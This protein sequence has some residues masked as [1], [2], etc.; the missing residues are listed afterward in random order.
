M[1]L[2]AFLFT[3]PVTGYAQLPMELP[4]PNAMVTLT[5]PFTPPLIKGII[6]YPENPLQFDF[7]IDPGD[8]DF[9][10]Q[11]APEKTEEYQK[12]VKYFLAAL[13]VPEND[14]WVNL[15]PYEKNRIIPDN[16]GKT[17][18]GRD[19]LSQDYILKQITASLMYP[20]KELG[21]EF[22]QKVYK[23]AQARFGTTD[24]PV[25]TFNK[26]WIIPDK[27]SVY[28][29]NNI[30]LL[31]DS[32]LKVMLEEDYLAL[33]Q[34]SLNKELGTNQ[35]VKKD[36]K[37]IS[38]VSS[39]IVREIILPAIEK[40]VNEGKNFA[41]LRQINNSLILATWYKT[42]LKESLLGK[43]YADRS[44][45]EGINQEDIKDNE[46]IYGQYLEA[47]KKGV[48]NYIKEEYDP[49]SQD[50][51]ARK[52]VSGGYSTIDA[53]LDN[54]ATSKDEAMLANRIERLPLS[55]RV[56]ASFP[57]AAD[58][59]TVNLREPNEARSFAKTPD[60]AMLAKQQVPPSD[61]SETAREFEKMAA[62]LLAPYFRS[63]GEKDTIVD[64]LKSKGFSPSKSGGLAKRILSKPSRSRETYRGSRRLS[65]EVQK[66]IFLIN[67]QHRNLPDFLRALFN[68]LNALKKEGIAVDPRLLG[69]RSHTQ[70]DV[71][72]E[73]WFVYPV[74][75]QVEAQEQ[76]IYEYETSEGEN[77]VGLI[78][79]TNGEV[80]PDAQERLIRYIQSNSF[81]V[82][83]RANLGGD[84]NWDKDGDA[85][86]IDTSPRK[87][88]EKKWL[89]KEYAGGDYNLY[90]KDLSEHDM[91]KILIEYYRATRQELQ[92]KAAGKMQEAR[93]IRDLFLHRYFGKER[94]GYREAME[95]LVAL[96]KRIEDASKERVLITKHIPLIE[97]PD[98]AVMPE[99]IPAGHYVLGALLIY[100]SANLA[101]LYERQDDDRVLNFFKWVSE[102]QGDEDLSFQRGVFDW[103]RMRHVLYLAASLKL[104][105][106]DMG[107]IEDF[108]FNLLG[109]EFGS[110]VIM[111]ARSN[112]DFMPAVFKETRQIRET[113]NTAHSDPL[114]ASQVALLN[115]LRDTASKLVMAVGRLSE[116]PLEGP[117]RRHIIKDI[118][119]YRQAIADGTKSMKTYIAGPEFLSAYE[120][121]LDSVIR[122]TS[123]YKRVIEFFDWVKQ[124]QPRT[125]A[126]RLFRDGIF[127]NRHLLLLYF[128]ARYL[129]D[130]MP[131]HP[132]DFFEA[133]EKDLEKAGGSLKKVLDASLDELNRF[134]GEIFG[135]VVEVL[136]LH[137]EQGN[138]AEAR[139]ISGN[140]KTHY[141]NL[142]R[143]GL[144]HPEGRKE[145]DSVLG[146]REMWRDFEILTSILEA[147][148]FLREHNMDLEILIKAVS[149]HRRRLRD[150]GM[151]AEEIEKRL[152]AAIQAAASLIQSAPHLEAAELRF[153]HALEGVPSSGEHRPPDAAMLADS[154][155]SQEHLQR[156]NVPDKKTQYYYDNAFTPGQFRSELEA[157]GYKKIVGVATSLEIWEE[158]I[159]RAKNAVRQY[160]QKFDS[161]T[162]VVVAGGTEFP[163]LRLVYEV[164]EEM[165]MKTVGVI[166]RNWLNDPLF[167]TDIMFVNG[168]KRG[169]ESLAFV[170]LIDELA[171]FAGGPQSKKEAEMILQQ[172]KDLHIY[173]GIRAKVGGKALGG[174]VEQEKNIVAV[175]K[176][177]TDAAML[178]GA[179]DFTK[180]GI[181]LNPANLNLQ[182]KRDGNGVP[183][184]IQFQDIPNINVE[185][186][187]PVIIQITPVTNLP[188]LFGIKTNPKE[189]QLSSL[190]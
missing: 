41:L 56:S 176:T 173:R 69:T 36:V 44:K 10:S 81:V 169:D 38:G 148:P 152:V 60:A 189:Q 43:V 101:Y 106:E 111:S 59:V 170:Q 4:A 92:K 80:R 15:S 84:K 82:L 6:I 131:R 183:L 31:V 58:Q 138:Y 99:H 142:A 8:V 5:P 187:L 178:A 153:V 71:L 9:K 83:T 68:V 114:R 156:R 39:K 159:F 3:F 98:P 184:P 46:K 47:F 157:Q 155:G 141:E 42:A 102:I 139:R 162:T 127:H 149:E 29:K 110:K 128:V 27:A 164:A 12:L 129:S 91:V 11:S 74:G 117:A 22:W 85:I 137:L 76:M 79:D 7:L 125:P 165:G 167:P 78:A 113:R 174:M 50:M 64:Y 180:G 166:V 112:P 109:N 24:I 182:I 21:K 16:F 30:V 177:V 88:G 94:P 163:G 37:D 20:E 103:E 77:I 14:L 136:K 150:G 132:G 96:A 158:D 154:K 2:V 116:A 147:N 100:F 52:Y 57:I 62:T 186:F 28:E 18:M 126:E 40:E 25:N 120:V 89:R 123:D 122:A 35:L 70:Y 108:L 160:L 95:R 151:A 1:V 54:P 124:L 171:I 65:A 73:R 67:F 34:N 75:L 63:D 104:E 121:I 17:E 86:V 118:R 140:F 119:Q 143:S 51:I 115:N 13:T 190:Q 32:H 72:E 135:I 48:Y 90:N 66:R 130:D 53:R 49:V 161:K 146:F 179:D 145:T 26:V 134:T 87:E 61:D 144:D 105:T 133:V 107:K 45:T 172:G 19:L 97:F 55:P 188:L 168:Q 93:N 181:D 23:E 175:A 185:G 33:E